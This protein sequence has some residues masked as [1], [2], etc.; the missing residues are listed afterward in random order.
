M[1][2]SGSADRPASGV[3][4]RWATVLLVAASLGVHL[5]LFVLDRWPEPRTLVGDEVTYW[6]RAEALRSGGSASSEPGAGLGGDG[7][8]LLWPPLYPR[9]LAAAWGATGGAGRLPVQGLQVALLL[10]AAL[11]LASFS[12]HLGIR[13]PWRPWVAAGIFGFPPLAAY[14]YYFW[15]EIPHLFFFALALVC[16][17]RPPQPRGWMWAAAGGI[18]L[19]LALL[20]KS[21]LTPLVPLLLLAL[22]MDR[23]GD[24]GSSRRWLRPAAAVLAMAAVVAPTVVA[25]HRTTGRAVIA[26]SGTFNLWVGLRDTSRRNHVDSIVWP[27]LQAYLASADTPAERDRLLRHR[28]AAHVEERGM[29]AVLVGQLG[30]QY[31]RLFDK[32]SYLTDQLPWGPI[33]TV[34]QGYLAFPERPGIW[35]RRLV[36]IVYGALL[37]AAAMGLAWTIG[38]GDRGPWGLTGVAFVGLNLLLFLG[39][40]VKT[41]Y[42]VPIEPFW[43]L[44]GVAALQAGWGRGGRPGTVRT[45]VGAVLALLALGLAFGARFAG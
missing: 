12:A 11:L 9:F 45:A 6:S 38:R 44:W 28:I 4:P 31:F 10:A 13:R 25:N 18:A 35:L 1:T 19:G 2:P 23:R 37:V 32:G 3:P 22:W 15:P 27:E 5:G 17:A 14:A 40:H 43:I 41:R 20:T 39:L 26:D 34:G 30:K 29:A 7:R 33:H 24:D 21:L 8:D 16:L 42:R 36:F